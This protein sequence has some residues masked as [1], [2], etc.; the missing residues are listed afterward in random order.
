MF[1]PALVG[2]FFSFSFFFCHVLFRRPGDTPFFPFLLLCELGDLVLGKGA[3]RF[4]DGFWSDVAFEKWV[5][6]FTPP[7]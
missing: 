2:I 7:E 5:F 1:R 3:G 4:F 6:T